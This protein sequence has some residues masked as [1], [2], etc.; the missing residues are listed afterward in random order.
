MQALCGIKIKV[1]L[2]L[3]MKAKVGDWIRYGG[4]MKDVIEK[5]LLV[6]MHPKIEREIYITQTDAVDETMVLEVRSKEEEK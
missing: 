6:R 5:V 3:T 2:T 4:W 1:H